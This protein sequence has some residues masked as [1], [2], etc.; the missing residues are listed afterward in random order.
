MTTLD[1]AETFAKLLNA[2]GCEATFVTDPT[3]ALDEARRLKPHIAFLD[4]G[5]PRFSGYELARALRK[6]FP[7]EQLKLVAVTAYN[8]LEYRKASR[9]AGFDAHV[10]KPV[11]PAIVEAIIKTVIPD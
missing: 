10:Q 3:Q 6:H 5:M 11:D 8:A 9:Q 1:V 2:C 4:I 7:P